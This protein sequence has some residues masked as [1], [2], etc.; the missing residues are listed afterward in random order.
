VQTTTKAPHENVP[1]TPVIIESIRV[2]E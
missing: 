1:A 2:V